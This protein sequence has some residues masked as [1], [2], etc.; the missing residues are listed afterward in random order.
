VRHINGVTAIGQV[1]VFLYSELAA[2]NQVTAL[3]G[4]YCIVDHW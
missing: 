2:P 1:R 3:P 4:S